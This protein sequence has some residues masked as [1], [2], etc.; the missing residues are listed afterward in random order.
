MPTIRFQEVILA[1]GTVG[2]ALA[3]N[4]FEFLGAP[5]V[6]QVFA[7]NDIGGGAAPGTFGVSEIEVFF[8]Q[9]IQLPQSILGDSAN[10]GEFPKVP[11]DELVNDVGAP[12]DRL[13]VRLVETGGA[14]NVRI[15]GMVKI[16]PIPMR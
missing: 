8:G 2:N 16:T 7:V 15:N 4:Q 9:E 3:G 1:G 10:A 11:D 14:L 6:V 13:V 5:S 12:G